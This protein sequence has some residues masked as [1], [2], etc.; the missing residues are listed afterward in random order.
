MTGDFQEREIFTAASSLTILSDQVTVCR[1]REGGEGLWK[2]SVGWR[3]RR[4]RRQ[5]HDRLNGSSNNNYH[6]H[7]A[8]MTATTTS[9]CDKYEATTTA[10][11]TQRPHQQWQQ[12]RASSS[13]WVLLDHEHALPFDCCCFFFPLP[14]GGKSWSIAYLYTSEDAEGREI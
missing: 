1:Q 12:Q 4:S 14:K 6:T 9:T 3:R 7:I 8:W 5:P 10:A 2:R 13:D 11:A